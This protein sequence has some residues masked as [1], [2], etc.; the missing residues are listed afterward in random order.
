MAGGPASPPACSPPSLCASR[1]RPVAGPYIR[2]PYRVLR[3]Y[4]DMTYEHAARSIPIQ[5]DDRES[6]GLVLQTLRQCGDFEVTVMRLPLGDYRLDGRFLFERKTMPDLVAAII[7]GRLFSQA[8]RLARTSLR[9]AI[10]LEGTARDLAASGMRWEAVQGALVTVALFCNIPLLRTRTPEETVRTMLFTARQGR[11]LASGALPR[12]GYRPR[13]KRARQIYI[14][15]G[16]PGIGPGRARRLLERFG[17]VEAVMKAG[18]EDL[19]SVTGIGERVAD[20]IRW[21]VEEPRS[22]SA[23]APTNS[24]T[25]APSIDGEDH[26]PD[27]LAA[28]DRL[29]CGHRLG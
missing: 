28:L 18:S 10:I 5:V 12:P 7:D 29:V 1:D 21:A 17:S 9:P 14:L 2:P 6:R 11:T 4:M 27:F 13:G 19:R 24:Y 26:M 8:L 23:F 25:G 22:L 16:L 20:K 15:Q 3:R